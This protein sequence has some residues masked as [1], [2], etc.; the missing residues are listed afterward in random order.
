M[1]QIRND[2]LHRLNGAVRYME[3]VWNPLNIVSRATERRDQL[4]IA[5]PGMIALSFA[6]KSA[7]LLAAEVL[8]PLW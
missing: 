1:L 8:P 3:I 5:A 7:L 2:R 4:R 6:D